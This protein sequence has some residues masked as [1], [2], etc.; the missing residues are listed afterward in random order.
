MKILKNTE[1]E[2]VAWIENCPGTGQPAFLF[3]HKQYGDVMALKVV[4]WIDVASDRVYF[5][6]AQAHE[7]SV[8]GKGNGY[9]ETS[10]PKYSAMT[11]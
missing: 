2:P 5:Y 8:S 6:D 9:Q 7:I 1:W 3:R 11:V 10:L 4:K